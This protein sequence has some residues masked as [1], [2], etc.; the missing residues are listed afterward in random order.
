ML[1]YSSIYP[2]KK[3]L[4][5]DIEITEEN[6]RLDYDSIYYLYKKEFPYYCDNILLKPRNDLLDI[7]FDKISS[8][9]N[10]Y[11]KYQKKEHLYFIIKKC[12][13]S[14]I[15]DEYIPMYNALSLTLS[16]LSRNSNCKYKIK[17]SALNKNLNYISSFMPHCLKHKTNNEF[18]I[19][20]CGEK[21]IQVNKNIIQSKSYKEKNNINI[22]RKEKEQFI[23][24][25]KCKKC[26][27]N[28]LILMFCKHCN[29]SYYS[30]LIDEKNNY[31]IYPATWEKYHCFNSEINN[32]INNYKFEE[33]MS[34]VKCNSKLWIKNNKLFCKNCN[35][36][37]DP[38]NLV[39]TCDKCDKE[40]RSNAKIYN[41]LNHKII[42]HIIRDALIGQKIVK[43]FDLP[44]ECI[45]KYKFDNVNFYHLKEGRCNGVLYY[46]SFNEK[47]Y[48]I[49]SLCKYIS[50]L[51]D[52]NWF[53]PFCLRYFIS[54]KIKIFVH[55][56]ENIQIY[57]RKC[58]FESKPKVNKYF[59]PNPTN[60]K[61]IKNNKNNTINNSRMSP[62]E[63]RVIFSQ[64][65]LDNSKCCIYQKD[66][67]D[68]EEK[69]NYSSINNK[70]DSTLY[71]SYRK[72]EYKRR[73]KCHRK[74]Y[75]CNN[76]I[77]KH[78]NNKISATKPKKSNLR[79]YTSNKKIQ[80]K[81]MTSRCKYNKHI[82]KFIF[83]NQK[84]IDNKNKN[85]IE[86]LN[87]NLKKDEI[88]LMK[89]KIKVSSSII[90]I[91]DNE[92]NDDENKENK[93]LDNNNKIIYNRAKRN[94]YYSIKKGNY[95][96]IYLSRSINNDDKIN[97]NEDNYN[98]ILS[99]FSRNIIKKKV[100][101]IK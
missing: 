92:F 94:K 22:N 61:I 77:D 10:H 75:S 67:K 17:C 21:L 80:D 33:Q 4:S 101:K 99:R 30:K 19:H 3:E 81:F 64:K 45:N 1:L 34:C 49:C 55:K 79:I 54:N 58:L 60:N 62:I 5:N 41:K 96:N 47:D 14:F 73:I 98:N 16:I 83:T 42:K 23:I 11:N 15:S 65:I 28:K 72:H 87:E 78:L 31:N 76:S 29:I 51:S 63:R 91:S 84:C 68:N 8:I 24:C 6:I 9:I 82:S 93:C 26:Y 97:D 85:F 32:E 90:N 53:C 12:E 44:C 35:F 39:W 56:K 27:K 88:K 7:L 50:Y 70:Y 43:P 20:I 74:L 40:F 46:N 86:E 25:P 52:F 66:K 18:A 95:N 13:N 37:I 89:P 69:N 59:S 38:T 36:E 57:L 2:N 100:M 71:T 48:V